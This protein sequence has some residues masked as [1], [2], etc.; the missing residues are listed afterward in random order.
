MINNM[1]TS[2]R[3]L[4]SVSAQRGSS[5]RA[6]TC[7]GKHSIW[8]KLGGQGCIVGKQ[9]GK[10]AVCMQEAESAAEMICDNEN[11]NIHF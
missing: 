9:Q 3:T 5:D 8:S 6:V 10:K 4:V 7:R 11:T 1:W 2:C